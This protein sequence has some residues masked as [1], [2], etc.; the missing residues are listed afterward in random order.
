VLLALAMPL[1][2]HH[3]TSA[4]DLTKS[5]TVSGVVEK[6][7]WA[8]PHSYVEL[9]VAGVHWRIEMEALNLLRR[10]GWTKATLKVGDR[11]SCT[12][13]RAKD[14]AQFTLKSFE[15]DLADGRKLKS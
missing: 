9:D 13:A 14:P 15:V 11:I 10:Q 8:N 2:A 7:Y 3:S 1:L 4:F 12:G 5:V 6:F